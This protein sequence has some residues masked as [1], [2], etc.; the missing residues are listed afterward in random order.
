MPLSNPAHD[1]AL[2][3]PPLHQ[4]GRRCRWCKT[5][6]R[7]VYVDA[8]H[9][10]NVD[11]TGATHCTPAARGVVPGAA[12][13]C[14]FGYYADAWVMGPPV[15]DKRGRYVSGAFDP[16]REVSAHDGSCSCNRS[17]PHTADLPGD[18]YPWP[19]LLPWHCEQPMQQRLYAPQLAA[20]LGRPGGWHCRAGGT[21]LENRRIVA[22]GCQTVLIPA[23]D[24]VLASAAA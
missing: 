20:E 2:L 15:T 14:V 17:M 12:G 21:S 7:I 9:D 24:V 16:L 4:S 23:D 11:E 19:D 18:P 1:R 13:H 10:V 3:G 8:R 6:I 22:I 5:Q